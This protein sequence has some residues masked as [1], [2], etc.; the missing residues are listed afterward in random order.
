VSKEVRFAAGLL[1]LGGG[2]DINWQKMCQ[3][4]KI[5][6]KNK[7]VPRT[8]GD[9]KKFYDFKFL[10]RQKIGRWKVQN[11]MVLLASKYSQRQ[12]RFL[13]IFFT[14]CKMSSFPI[15]H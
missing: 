11:A 6:K 3:N 4:E 5:S 7:D 12:V 8:V 9:N 15:E 13:S 14:G 1:S 10:H 2:T